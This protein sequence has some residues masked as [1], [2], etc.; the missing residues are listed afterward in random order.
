MARPGNLRKEQLPTGEPDAGNPPVRFGRGGRFYPAPYLILRV[1]ALSH[2]HF[3]ASFEF[4]P[5]W[6]SILDRVSITPWQAA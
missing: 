4:L 5:L 2:L 1:F 3:G 6:R